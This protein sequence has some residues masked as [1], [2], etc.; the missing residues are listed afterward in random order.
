V[1]S[2]APRYQ[3]KKDPAGRVALITSLVIAQQLGFTDQKICL[4][5]QLPP[6]QSMQAD[7]LMLMPWFPQHYDNYRAARAAQIGFQGKMEPFSIGDLMD[8]FAYMFHNWGIS[9]EH[10]LSTEQAKPGKLR[11]AYVQ[12]FERITEHWHAGKEIAADDAA[13]WVC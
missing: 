7:F 11:T 9:D 5:K 8:R 4:S 3:W 12:L 10:P 6:K 2:N 1:A 13:S